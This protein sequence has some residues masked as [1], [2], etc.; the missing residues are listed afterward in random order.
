MDD[1]DAYMIMI[2]EIWKK[3]RLADHNFAEMMQLDKWMNPLRGMIILHIATN[4]E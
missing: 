2:K 3:I 1:G 4:D